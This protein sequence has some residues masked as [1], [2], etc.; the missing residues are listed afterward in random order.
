MIYGKPMMMRRP[1]I[2]LKNSTSSPDVISVSV[3]PLEHGND[4]LNKVYAGTEPST[5]YT[6]SDGGEFWE[7]MSTLN[8]LRSSPSWSFL[9]RPC[10]HHVRWIEP[11]VNNPTYVFLAIEAGALVH[12]RDGGKNLDRPSSAK[13]I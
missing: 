9:P 2:V 12:T 13:P 11:D 4:I 8:D 6:S 3:S 5:L 1:R 7:R 10:T